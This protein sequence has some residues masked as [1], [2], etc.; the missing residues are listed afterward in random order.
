[1]APLVLASTSRYRRALLDSLGLLFEARAPHCNE[2]PFPAEAPET[3]VRRFALEKARSLAN[4][5]PGALIVGSDQGVELDGELLGKPGTE[6][7]AVSQLLRLSGRTHRLLTAVTVHLAGSGR[8]ASG[9]CVHHMAMRPLT[10]D[11]AW[12]YVRQD[13]PLDCA[14]AYRVE[15][16]GTALFEEMQGPDH[17]G[18]IGLPLTLVGNLVEAIGQRWLART[19]GE[20]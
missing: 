15:G 20:K 16:L 14:G 4:E 9:L 10:R 7:A 11:Q 6:E 1:M 3:A 13:A 17:T 5:C 19:L 12:A 8:E 2:V 18:I